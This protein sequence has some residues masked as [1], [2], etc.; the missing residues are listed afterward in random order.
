[1][2]RKRDLFYNSFGKS[3]G[4]GMALIPTVVDYS[5]WLVLSAY[6][7]YDCSSTSWTFQSV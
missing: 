6:I 3:S 2:L 5:L 7:V 1:M 4:L